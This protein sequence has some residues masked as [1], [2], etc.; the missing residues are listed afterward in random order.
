MVRKR[1]RKVS[2]RKMPSLRQKIYR[3]YVRLLHKLII[4]FC[5]IIFVGGIIF[6]CNKYDL[7][8]F[9][10]KQKAAISRVYDGIDVSKYQ[11]TIDWGL[12]A[13][14]EKIQFVYIKASEGAS[15][16][17]KRYQNYI[18]GAKKVGLKV[19]SYHYFI[20]R[21]TAKE[22]FANFNKYVDKEEQDLIPM[23]DV[24][25]FGNRFV[26]RKELQR[27]LNEFMQMIKEKYGKYPLLY[28]QYGFYKEKLSPEF[29]KYFLFIARYGDTPPTLNGAGKHNIWQYTEKGK[30]KGIKGFV[31][32]DRFE[33]GTKLVDIEMN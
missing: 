18:H 5:I 27:N 17:D 6:L 26:S 25:E 29:D 28:S 33:N 7:L 24:E 3:K 23:V 16:V 11:G 21:K 9:E 8:Q 14:D 2:K 12:V 31:D 22:Q 10:L 19:G 4:F 1:K 13:Q 20:G 32:L 15:S 30:I